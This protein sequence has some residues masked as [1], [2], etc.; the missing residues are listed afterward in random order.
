MTQEKALTH[1]RNGDHV[2]LTGPAGSGKTTV[3]QQF[4]QWCHENT[5]SVAITASTGIAATH[6]GG[7]TI[8]SWSGIGI[9]DHLS[10]YEIE[11]L[12]QREYLHARLNNCSVLIID[13]IS[14]LDA[15]RLDMID[16]IMRIIRQIDEPFGGV[17]IVFSGDFFQLPPINRNGSQNHFAF[18]SRVWQE[19]NI[20][21]CY[22][23]TIYRQSDNALLSILEEIRNG[24]VSEKN[25]DL[26]LSRIDVTPNLNDVVTQLFTH[27]VDVDALNEKE[28]Q[29]LETPVEVFEMT[30][31]GQRGSVQQL[32]KYCL[33]PV[34]LRLK[35]GAKVMFVKNNFSLGVA[36]GTLGTVVDF[37]FGLPIVET[38]DGKKISVEPDT[39]SFEQDGK[40]QAQIQQLPLRLAWGITI[41]KSQGMT[42][43]SAI[44]DLSKAFAPGMGYV[45]LS[46]VRSLDGM[47][48]R[49]INAQSLTVHHKVKEKDL[50]FRLQ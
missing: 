14:M 50:F 15:H 1:L 33:A 25:H 28:L 32:K 31:S 13:E 6:I 36:N 49:G 7:T 17:Q 4:I 45:A 9:S 46:R 29:S 10:E 35:K 34:T 38:T 11:D 43:D 20:V 40:I 41:H 12:S 37:D 22:L 27:N 23:E 42:L 26:L 39:W 48:L 16:T 21:I 24:S 30:S 8:H 5:I 19:L 47:Y 2:F 3:L 44:I 18:E